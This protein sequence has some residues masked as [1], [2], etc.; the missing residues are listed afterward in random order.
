MVM[1]SPGRLLGWLVGFFGVLFLELD[2]I[3]FL[4]FVYEVF[5]C[6]V[7]FEGV[8]PFVVVVFFG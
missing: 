7:Y 3:V 6:F 8:G 4:V 1:R 2:V 5:Y